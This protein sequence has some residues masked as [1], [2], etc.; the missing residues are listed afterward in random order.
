M[1]RLLLHLNRVLRS[2]ALFS[3][4]QLLAQ[5]VQKRDEEAFRLLVERHGPVV[6]GVCRR[7]LPNPAD[8]DDAFQATFLILARRANSI[9]QPERLSSWLHSVALR[10]ARKL[11]FSLDR[12]QRHEELRAQLPHAVV[13]PITPS[14]DLAQLLDEELGRL[15]EKLRLPMLLCHVQ[16]LSRREA[17][18]RLEIPE[19]TLSTWLNQAR[20]LLRKRLM[21]RGIVPAVA[22]SVLASEADA[23]PAELLRAT[24]EAAVSFTH[25][26]ATATASAA[27]VRLAQGV[28]R[29]LLVK[30]LTAASA[31]LFLV[32]FLGAGIGLFLNEQA[33]GPSFA[34]DPPKPGG[35]VEGLQVQ[36][37]E[38]GNKLP[39]ITVVEKE[40][41]I[42]VNTV[43]ALGRYLKRL[44]TADKSLPDSITIVSNAE[45]KY[46]T[47]T[48]VI[49]AC[50]EA[51]FGVQIASKFKDVIDGDGLGNSDIGLPGTKAIDKSRIDLLTRLEDLQKQRDSLLAKLRELEGAGSP[52]P[53][54]KGEAP[55]SP[56]P[57]ADQGLLVQEAQANLAIQQAGLLGA[58]AEAKSAQYSMEYYKIN[59]EKYQELFKKFSNATNEAEVR[60]ADAEYR[61]SQADFEFK[62][63]Q[64]KKAEAE[65]QLAKARLDHLKKGGQLP[66]KNKTA[67]DAP[68]DYAEALKD[69][70][71]A[72]ERTA[73]DEAKRK[74]LAE[75]NAKHKAHVDQLIKDYDRALV[76]MAAHLDE[77]KLRKYA[78]TSRVTTHNELEPFQGLWQVTEVQIDG[79]APLDPKRFLEDYWIVLD[80]NLITVSDGKTQMYK[81]HLSRTEGK[82]QFKLTLSGQSGTTFTA[83]A[84]FEQQGEK[85]KVTVI[86]QVGSSNVKP[87]PM[88]MTLKR[89]A[90][91]KGSTGVPTIPTPFPMTPAGPADKALHVLDVEK[92]I[93]AIET[94]VLVRRAELKSAEAKLKAG[95]LD[96]ERLQKLS[97]DKLV[98]A[99]ELE[100]A[101]LNVTVLQAD[102]EATQAKLRSAESQLIIEK[103]RLHDLQA[104]PDE[105]ARPKP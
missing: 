22:L 12:R 65:L 68:A 90:T 56:P 13:P 39:Q 63:S 59:L 35:K 29:M 69:Y 11:R 2:A 74:D 36:V 46:S 16:G 34:A 24:A 91:D 95:I 20:L 25:Q 47:M 18:T 93:L 50:K 27:V 23:V 67:K 3:D 96:L 66:E 51:G 81:I 103:K 92:Q 83:D 19:G 4:A 61:R 57:V 73:L 71:R 54:G 31:A 86:P 37:F 21:R 53:A 38:S 40:D 105:K 75:Q 41:R 26:A 84:S 32:F 43:A 49:L 8:R 64:V 1:N 88:T 15:P 79:K 52:A 77:S 55:I 10:T 82:P 99:A 44:R 100:K 7:W 6:R 45:T 9:S 5:F 48:E 97:A 80:D 87:P 14:G 85:I 42:N 33:H 72:L 76:D 17:A 62:Q 101:K 60:K 94:E 104:R 28:L 58:Q 102:V 30:R 78:E 98:S 70:E 89:K